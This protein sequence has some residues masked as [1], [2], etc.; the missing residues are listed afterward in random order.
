MD[1]LSCRCA[2]FIANALDSDSDVVIYVSRHGVYY[3]RMLSLEMYISAAQDGVSLYDIAFI[4]KDFVRIATGVCSAC[5][6]S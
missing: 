6:V 2:K 1:E 3:G 5:S 4:I